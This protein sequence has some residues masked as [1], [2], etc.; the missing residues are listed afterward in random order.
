MSVR[1]LRLSSLLLAAA[2]ALCAGAQRA[3]AE[4][5]DI[6][7][8]FN[9]NHTITVELPDHT[10]V[11]TTSG[12]PTSI[13]AGG[14][15]LHF[16]D[17]VGVSGPSFRLNGPGAN[18]TENLT[19]GEYPSATLF[20]ALQPNT[21]YTWFN[22]EQPNNVFRFTTTS[23]SVGVSTGSQSSGSGKSSTS[24]SQDIVGSANKTFRGSLDAIVY[25]SG[26]L[27]LAKSNKV[28]KSLRSGSYTF[29]V[30]DES[31]KYGF[32]VQVLK[33]KAKTIT[34]KS[35]VG[36]HNVTMTLKPGRWSF[37][38]PGGKQTTFF[39]TS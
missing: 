37:F 27:S 19:Y 11:G 7:I 5:S 34:G 13:A 39:V 18:F 21:A 36:N 15:N 2:L 1:L 22:E 28:V 9:T 23:Q 8:T 29:S 14:Y 38:T 20:V 4:G 26:K 12:T 24:Q 16:D 3:A 33:G 17:T 10:F 35:Y 30:D 25:K 32:S 31:P 6:F